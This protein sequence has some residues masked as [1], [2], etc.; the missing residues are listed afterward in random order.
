MTK[1]MAKVLITGGAGFIGSHTADLLL[2]KGYKVR[3]L[4]SLSPTTHFGNWPENLDPEIEKIKSDVRKKSDLEKALKSTDFVIHLAA[5]MDLR[6]EFSEFFD[7]NTKSTA[8]IFELIVKNKLP[9][10]KIIIASSQFVYGEGRWKCSVHGE[11]FPKN[12]NL[13]DL[14]KGIWDPKCPF[15]SEKITPLP[16]LETHQDPPNPYAISKFTQELIGL[17]LGKLFQI[18]TVVLRYSIAHGPQ[19]SLKNFYSGALRTFTLQMLLGQNPTIFED[20]QQLRDYVSVYD[21][22]SANL[23]VLE[24]ERANFEIFNVGGG[25]GLSV[26]ELAKLVAKKLGVNFKSEISGQFR[27]G[28]IRHAVSDISKLKNL[29]WKPKISE[30]KAVSDYIDWVKTQKI[31][32]RYLAQAQE[33]LEQFEILKRVS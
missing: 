20:G 22:A 3:I 2:K 18:P 1:N 32:K 21:V 25:V 7:T 11:V 28:D 29:G 27:L 30:E 33:Q 6:P 16:S 26:L 31:E 9:V 8:L 24:N 5:F 14:E 17:K 4:D 15:G 23:T 19:Q 12:R 13:S 10:K